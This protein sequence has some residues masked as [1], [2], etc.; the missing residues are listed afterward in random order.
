MKVS[1]IIVLDTVLESLPDSI[2][3]FL[4]Q[5]L[6]EKELIIFNNTGRALALAD[7]FELLSTQVILIN[8]GGQN[9]GWQNAFEQSFE[10][11]TGQFCTVWEQSRVYMPWHLS[12]ALKVW[13]DCGKKAVRQQ[14]GILNP[15]KKVS[16]GPILVTTA[17]VAK[18]LFVESEMGP[19]WLFQLNKEDEIYGYSGVPSFRET[20]LIVEL[21]EQ[22]VITFEDIDVM[23]GRWDWDYRALRNYMATLKGEQLEQFKKLLPRKLVCLS[24]CSDD[25][26]QLWQVEVCIHNFRKH[27]LADKMQICV[28]YQSDNPN[29]QFVNIAEKNT[30][31]QFFFYKNN[32]SNIA[33][34][35]SALRPHVF[36]MHFEKYPELKDCAIFYHDS[37]IIFTETPNLNHLSIGPDCYVGNT[38]EYI[39]A[40]YILQNSDMRALEDMCGVVGISPDMVIGKNNQSG[41][42]Q[43]LMKDIDSAFWHE[44]EKDCV[45]LYGQIERINIRLREEWEHTDAAI[46]KDEPKHIQI[47]T[48]DMW[49]V[50]WNLWLRGKETHIVDE[51]S[52]VW[53]TEP[54]QN[55]GNKP[56]LH[57]SGVD[58]FWK[59]KGL[60]AKSN[61]IS[62]FPVAAD[63]DLKL[64]NQGYAAYRYAQEVA[65]T[66]AG[67]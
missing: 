62:R 10:L 1:G 64:L 60:F 67:R 31:V 51:L 7:R 35:I 13:V 55:V 21:S 9:V 14:S 58:Y 44:V 11:V 36:K 34:Y 3:S 38:M 47:F 39:S 59:Q 28:F 16:N 42:A 20:P 54:I 61:Y 24:A 32:A 18:W 57:N 37:D 27:G 41:G 23:T 53:S 46:R 25:Q 50:L 30:D 52:F 19:A 63:L 48:A 8:E 2:A 17:E 43:Y 4:H 33:R 26:Y 45:F 56:I 65:E 66:F 40:A 5:D 15:E 6:K 49:A 29:P 12:Q 22:N